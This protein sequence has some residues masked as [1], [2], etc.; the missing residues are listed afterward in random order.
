[1]RT[2]SSDIVSA[3]S[4]SSSRHSASDPTA[5]RVRD[6]TDEIFTIRLPAP[7]CNPCAICGEY[8][9]NN[10]LANG[11]QIT[12]RFDGGLRHW[13]RGREQPFGPASGRQSAQNRG[14]AHAPAPSVTPAKCVSCGTERRACCSASQLASRRRGE[15]CVIRLG[16]TLPRPR[17]FSTDSLAFSNRANHRGSSRPP[18]R[19]QPFALTAGRPRRNRSLR[20]P[21]AP[22]L[23]GL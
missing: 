19:R 2:S 7:Q 5:E 4:P 18:S 3:S 11:A 13:H 23:T 8:A 20:S 15:T 17:S 1:M 12:H 21:A 10:T 22:G 9:A 16:R 6:G 14:V